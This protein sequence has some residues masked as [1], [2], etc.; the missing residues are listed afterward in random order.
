MSLAELPAHKDKVYRRNC[1]E[2]KPRNEGR[3]YISGKERVAPHFTQLIY[4][5]QVILRNFSKLAACSFQAHWL[6][7]PLK[8]LTTNWTFYGA[9]KRLSCFYWPTVYTFCLSLGLRLA[10]L[11]LIG[12]CMR[13]FYCFAHKTSYVLALPSLYYIITLSLWHFANF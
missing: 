5:Y 12:D 10:L 9:F 8:L 4:K 1:K 3:P 2:K 11:L 13:I 7:S 6:P